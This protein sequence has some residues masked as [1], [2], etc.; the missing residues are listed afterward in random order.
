M[1]LDLASLTSIEAFCE[2]LASSKVDIDAF[3]NNAG[4][5][6]QPGKKPADGF[7]LVIG[8]NYIG[9]Y[10][11]SERLLPYISYPISYSSRQ[12]S[13]QHQETPQFPLS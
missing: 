4:A 5:F 7:D 10:Y 6:R 9:T 13:H 3:V 11:L 2:E 1:P 8:T 12:E